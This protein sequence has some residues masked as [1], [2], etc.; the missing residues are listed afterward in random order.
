MWPLLA[1]SLVSL[2]V[3][4]ERLLFWARESR[5]QR[6][7][8]V[9]DV[10]EALAQ[11]D[12]RRAIATL[13]AVP[14]SLARVL[15]A[16]IGARRPEPAMQAVASR[17][18]FRMKRGMGV[19]DTIITMAPLLGILGTV[20]GIITSFDILSGAVDPKTVTR[21]IAQALLTTASGLTVALLTLLP[22]NYLIHRVERAASDLEEAST[23]LLSFGSVINTAV[24]DAKPGGEG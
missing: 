16:G 2:T 20:I 9:V 15:L 23:R 3:T 6:Q 19:L 13:A 22:H 24:E 18:V 21:G 4:V 5:A 14:C 7:V 11:G 17:E 12:T 10:Y 8:G 1:S